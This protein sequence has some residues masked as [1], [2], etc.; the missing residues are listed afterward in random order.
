MRSRPSGLRR[1]QLDVE[2]TR[3]PARDLVLEGE[4]IARIAVEP[5]CPEMRVG[6]GVNQLGA[7]AELVAR[8]PDAAP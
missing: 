8:S 4:H 7:D 6:F 1:D 2:R 5:V 3:D